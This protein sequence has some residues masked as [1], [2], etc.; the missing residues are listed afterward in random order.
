MGNGVCLI[1]RC[2]QLF[3]NVT[4]MYN[5]VLLY[6]HFT[7]SH[8]LFKISFYWNIAH[9]HAQLLYNVV[10]ISAVQQSASALCIHV[11]KC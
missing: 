7:S 11:E 4:T 8:G 1:N 5:K 6:S 3:R 2:I 10:F 9:I